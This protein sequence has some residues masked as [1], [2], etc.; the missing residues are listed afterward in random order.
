MRGIFVDTYRVVGRLNFRMDF[1]SQQRLKQELHVDVEAIEEG[2]E[3]LVLNLL[4]SSIHGNANL[5]SGKLIRLYIRK[6]L[7]DDVE[8]RRPF[9]VAEDV[10]DAR[11]N[12]LLEVVANP[13]E[14]EHRSDFEGVLELL[15]EDFLNA[16][17]VVEGIHYLVQV[18]F[19][20]LLADSVEREACA[21]GDVQNFL[22]RFLIHNDAESLVGLSLVLSFLL[23][24]S[25]CFLHVND[26]RNNPTS[27]AP[28]ALLTL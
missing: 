26:V 28:L 2:F 5:H 8:T 17:R 15:Y 1:P 9:F 22:V 18:N 6:E 14:L 23:K 4:V 16:P 10:I 7:R 19:K 11:A 25:A 27:A 13:C 24:E 3:V 21:L 12:G 20:D